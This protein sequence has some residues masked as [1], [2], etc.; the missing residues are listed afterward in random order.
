MMRFRRKKIPMYYKIML[1]F[2][3]LV[4]VQ[5]GILM[6][7]SMLAQNNAEDYYKTRLLQRYVAASS[8][9]GSILESNNWSLE[10]EDFFDYFEGYAFR[11]EL[12]VE[13][14][15]L[16]GKLIYS[17]ID[18]NNGE[19]NNGIR[20]PVLK[21]GEFAN[22]DDAKLVSDQVPILVNDQEVGYI[23]VKFYEVIK[24]N[25]L[26]FFDRISDV[27]RYTII[28]TVFITLIVSFFVARSITVPLKKVS[29]TAGAIS[30]GN[31]D[32]RAD[33]QSSTTEIVELSESIN[34]LASTLKQEDILRKQVTSDMAHEIR[35]PLT[36]LRNFFEAFM[37][38]IYEPNT[39]NMTKCH[40]EIIRMTDLVD[41]LKD[42]A[43]IEEGNISGL[44]E[45]VNLSE[46]LATMCDLLMPAYDKKS[47]SL[48]TTMHDQVEIL[49]NRNHLRQIISNLLT[50]AQRYSDHGSSVEIDV[51]EVN[52]NAIFTVKDEGFGMSQE[53]QTSIFER[54]Y[55]ADKSRDR[56]TGGMGVGLTIVKTLVERYGGTIS[57]E[58]EIGKGSCFKVTLPLGH[59]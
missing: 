26:N 38:G 18:V 33:I 57:V 31:L 45:K 25:D 11:H 15:N 36:A 5:M 56:A 10:D 49:I 41:R 40:D 7:G 13:L 9:M 50:N 17:N 12:R 32:A 44:K 59:S 8:E 28:A 53:D 43:Q 1:A 4:I 46:E 24:S 2:F 37:D 16:E 29:R 21:R 19:I 20:P 48:T 35:T 39:E 42:L 30:G 47:M 22:G 58:S 14:F 3:A 51:F 6:V 34:D 55:R 52:D 23:E 27:F 54:F